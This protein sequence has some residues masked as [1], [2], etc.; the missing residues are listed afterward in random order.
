M[1]ED[2]D[3]CD[4]ANR[5]EWSRATIDV[6]ST[7]SIS[8]LLRGLAC[9]EYLSL[10]LAACGFPYAADV[11]VLISQTYLASA[12]Y[13]LVLIPEPADASSPVYV[14]NNDMPEGHTV[15]LCIILS[16]GTN[17]STNDNVR[18]QASRQSYDYVLLDNPT[19]CFS[20]LCDTHV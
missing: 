11:R 20:L 1:E 12:Y 17:C 15:G 4:A 7:G 16:D 6:G 3:V 14:N 5:L 18:Q 13:M 10:P 19:T 8:S 9:A 2:L